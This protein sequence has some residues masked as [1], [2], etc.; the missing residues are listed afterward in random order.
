MNPQPKL[1][2]GEVAICMK[3]NTDRG[4]RM[5]DRVIVNT[6]GVAYFNYKNDKGSLSMAFM[7]DFAHADALPELLAEPMADIDFALSEYDELQPPTF[8]NSHK[9]QVGVSLNYGDE[10]GFVKAANTLGSDVQGIYVSGHA[11]TNADAVKL[12]HA[13]MKRIVLLDDIMKDNHIDI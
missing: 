4:Y 2:A 12:V 9:G 3:S 7:A 8:I 13:L 1:R 5:G 11:L 6:I 10:E